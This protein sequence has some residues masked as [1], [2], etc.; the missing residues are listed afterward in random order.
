MTLF[1]YTKVKSEPNED[2]YP[3]AYIKAGIKS[4][5]IFSSFRCLSN[6]FAIASQWGLNFKFIQEIMDN[7]VKFIKILKIKFT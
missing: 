2:N 7:F 3:K 4:G 1:K 5:V 6:I